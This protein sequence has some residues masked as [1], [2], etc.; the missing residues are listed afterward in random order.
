MKGV[1]RQLGV[2]QTSQFCCASL[3]SCQLNCKG[4]GATLRHWCCQFG[5]RIDPLHPSHRLQHQW[6][7][8]FRN[9]KQTNK[10][11]KKEERDPNALVWRSTLIK[12][13]R[14]APGGKNHY[15]HTLLTSSTWDPECAEPRPMIESVNILTFFMLVPATRWARLVLKSGIKGTG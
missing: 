4:C 1:T 14:P 10:L 2:G 3:D 12:R 5:A 6:R 9:S 13:S 7:L 8:T 15:Q 11:V